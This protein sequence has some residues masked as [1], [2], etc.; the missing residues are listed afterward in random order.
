[1]TLKTATRLTAENDY[2]LDPMAK[3]DFCRWLEMTEK[4]F[5]KVVDKHANK[6]L[7]E[8]RDGVWRLK[9]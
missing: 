9:R 7:V 8:K 2:M 6:K 1:M 4:E 3:A 5:D